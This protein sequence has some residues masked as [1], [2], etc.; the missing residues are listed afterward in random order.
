MTDGDREKFDAIRMNLELVSLDL[1]SMRA[2]DEAGRAELRESRIQTGALRESVRDLMVNSSQMIAS[3]QFN[4]P[5][6]GREVRIRA[7][8]G[9]VA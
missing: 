2:R 5:S 9:K 7:V 3:I 1:E 6:E 8:E 4:N